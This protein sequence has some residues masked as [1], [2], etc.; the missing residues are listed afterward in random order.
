[1]WESHIGSRFEQLAAYKA[2]LLGAGPPTRSSGGCGLNAALDYAEGV[3]TC[4]T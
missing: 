3:L 1:M 4:A 2:N